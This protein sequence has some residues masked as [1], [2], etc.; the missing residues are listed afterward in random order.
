MSDMLQL[1]DE[2]G[3]TL[4]RPQVRLRQAKAYR[5]SD[6][7][8]PRYGTDFIH[9]WTTL[10]LREGQAMRLLTLFALITIAAVVANAQELPR[11]WV[12]PDTGH[13]VIRLSDE[14][15]SA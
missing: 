14:P 13:R 3:Q 10:H 6:P 2:I 4:A 7:T 5:T 1:V 12:D 8:L 9:Y 11:E 15:G